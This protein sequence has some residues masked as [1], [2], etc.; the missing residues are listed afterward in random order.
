MGGGRGSGQQQ[1]QRQEMGTDHL[2]ILSKSSTAIA[3]RHRDAAHDVATETHSRAIGASTMRI[4][5]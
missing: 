4:T 1:R 3:A 2:V 5:A